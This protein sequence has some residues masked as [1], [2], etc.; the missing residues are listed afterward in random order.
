MWPPDLCPPDAQLTL[1]AFGTV[2]EESPLCSGDIYAPSAPLDM[3]RFQ[4]T[5]LS[6]E[7]ELNSLLG[8]KTGYSEKTK[9]FEN[10]TSS[11]DCSLQNASIS[12]FSLPISSEKTLPQLT[13]KQE[14]ADD[15]FQCKSEQFQVNPYTHCA[16]TNSPNSLH[17][18]LSVSQSLESALEYQCHWMECST[19]SGSQEELVRHIEKVHIDQ[20]KG[21]EFTCFWAGCVRRHKPFNARYKLLIHMRVHSGE[22]PNKCM[23][24]GCSKAFSRLENLKI[25]LRSHTGEKPYVCQHRGCVKLSVTPATEPSTRGR[26]ST[27]SKPY[28]C[29]S[30]GCSKR[31]TD[32]SSLRKHV[33][34]H[35]ARGLHQR[36]RKVSSMLESD[37]LSD[38]LSRQH[39]NVS[40]S[41]HSPSLP[42]LA[43]T[44]NSPPPALSW[45]K[46]CECFVV[47]KAVLEQRSGEPGQLA[48]ASVTESGRFTNRTPSIAP[49]THCK[50]TLNTHITN[51]TPPPLSL[52]LSPLLFPS[53]F[54]IFF[55][56]L[57]FYCIYA[58]GKTPVE[59]GRFEQNCFFAKP[60]APHSSGLELLLD[61]QAQAGGGFSPDEHFLFQSSGVS[62][63]DRCIS[64][65]CS[66]YLDS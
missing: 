64:H 63:V 41:N 22:K 28:A 31:Y 30:P 15:M 10:S 36:D 53:P 35:S 33:K 61:L 65:L 5:S 60:S 21:E 49:K 34:A 39:L 43:F 12:T 11:L 3:C 56:P 59:D 17:S 13:I 24:E 38:C 42:G 47:F 1:P 6:L 57:L 62:G 18:P 9:P 50:N 26:T 20:R 27:R 16:N 25:H 51:T 4:K 54:L 55:S 23:F 19:A 52:S 66:V 46:I 7:R 2:F 37:L 58:E 8:F 44:G 29:Q 14:P 48:S 40:Q 45:T 32:P